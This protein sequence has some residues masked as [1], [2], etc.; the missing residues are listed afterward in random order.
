MKRKPLTQG[1]E[2]GFCGL[3]AV[4]NV[5][6][7]LFP[8]DM[9]EV[10]RA[11]VFKTLARNTISRWPDVVWDGTHVGDIRSMLDAGSAFLRL[12]GCRV[13]WEEPYQHRRFSEFG[14]FVRELRWRIEGDDAFA[15]VG[16]TKPWEHWTAT[17]RV[18]A[19]QMIMTDLCRIKRIPL[20]R[21]GVHGAGADYEFDCRQT[22]ILRRAPQ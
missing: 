17:H 3:Y 21:C 11:D 16:L 9:D 1:D 8:V 14:E 20:A 22:F 5:L 13:D 2:D 12:R 19:R 18:T 10:L 7:L 15:I 6:S 4:T